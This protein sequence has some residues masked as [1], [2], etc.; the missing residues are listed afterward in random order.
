M[1][2][3]FSEANPARVALAV[4]GGT[5]IGRPPDFVAP[6]S[7]VAALTAGQWAEFWEAFPAPLPDQVM[8]YMMK[9][10]D[11]RA[12]G[13]ELGALGAD[14]RPW[15]RLPVP[16]IG[17]R[18]VPQGLTDL[19]AASLRRSWFLLAQESPPPPASRRRARPRSSPRS[20]LRVRS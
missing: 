4:L 3:M 6:P 16:A 18:A 10:N 8:D 17:H 9:T 1:T 14:V 12:V 7:Q 11:P 2:C 19:H 15:E 5:P 13:A 20:R